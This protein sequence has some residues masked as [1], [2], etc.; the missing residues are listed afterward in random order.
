MELS[1]VGSS[2]RVQLIKF[3]V[4]GHSLRCGTGR[5][6][7]ACLIGM[8]AAVV[9]Q[10]SVQAIDLV[11]GGLLAFLCRGDRDPSPAMYGCQA[12]PAPGFPLQQSI[13]KGSFHPP[14]LPESALPTLSAV[15]WPPSCCWG[16][17]LILRRL[18]YRVPATSQG[19][20]TAAAGGP[21]GRTGA[22]RG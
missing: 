20:G 3:I 17:F 16:L 15:K 4:P 2:V 19:A 9:Y 21:A 6:A 1:C 8:R 14:A 11:A 7:G 10:P 22:A 18:S 13:H 12:L 5:E